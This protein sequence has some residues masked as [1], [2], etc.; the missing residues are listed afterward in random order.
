MKKL[1]LVFAIVSV[2]VL[3][4]CAPAAP[5][6]DVAAD[7]AAVRK[8]FDE[9]TAALNANGG[10]IVDLWIE[11]AVAMFAHAPAV[12]GRDAAWE[13]I[14]HATTYEVTRTMDEVVVSGDWAFVRWSG[15]GTTTPKDGGE[16]SEFDIKGITILQRQPDN[17][18]E[19]ARVI[20][21]SNL[22]VGGAAD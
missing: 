6:V 18:W 11:D 1:F 3:S 13:K 2:F 4:G 7:E 10:S 15:K 9:E 17:S 19:M 16:P 12:T 8:S 14:S 22:P 5:Q 20:L 21:N